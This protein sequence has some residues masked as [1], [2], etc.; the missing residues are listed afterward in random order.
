MLPVVK[1]YSIQVFKNRVCSQKPTE[2]SGW[3]RSKKKPVKNPPN[4]EVL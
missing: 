1:F 3:T 2:F 4:F